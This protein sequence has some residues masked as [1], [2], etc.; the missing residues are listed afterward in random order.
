MQIEATCDQ[1]KLRFD[2]LVHFA[3]S[4]F[5]VLIELPDDAV[6][7]SELQQEEQ[8]AGISCPFGKRA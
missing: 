1:G 2:Q 7:S 5:R 3:R 4:R 6:I 8:L